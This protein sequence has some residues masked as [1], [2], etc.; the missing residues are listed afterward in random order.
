MILI[1][2]LCFVL[3]DILA[4]FHN[5]M[6]LAYAKGNIVLGIFTL[7]PAPPPPREGVS[8]LP[9]DVRDT[10]VELSA[11]FGEFNDLTCM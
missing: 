6:S 8:D 3:F 2:N 11:E 9:Y 7:T 10:T 5:R 4:V 1:N